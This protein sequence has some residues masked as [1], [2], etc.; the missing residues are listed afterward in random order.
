MKKSPYSLEQDL[1][2]R[3][4]GSD[5]DGIGG[6][7]R[8]SAEDFFVQ[9]IP[10]PSGGETGPYLVCR[11][12]KK[13]WEQQHAI[14]EIAR[15]LGISHRR[16][17]WAGTK[18]RRAVTTQLISIYKV[19][20]EMVESIRLKDIT[21]EVVGHRNT[22]LSLGDLEGNRFDITIREATD[23]DPATTVQTITR[24]IARGIPNYYGIQR[25]GGVR[26]VTH[27]VGERILAGDYEGAVVTYIGKSF[28]LENENTRHARMEFDSTRDSEDALRVFPVSLAYERAMLQHLHNNPKDYPG[29][30]QQLPPKLLSMFV[31]AFQSY[32]FNE[33]VSR[34]IEQGYTFAEPQPGDRLLFTN[35]KED[36]VSERNRH[37]ALQHIMRGRCKIAIFMPGKGRFSPFSDSEHYMKGLMEERG[38]RAENFVQASTF[39]KTKF[40]GALRP[41]M[42]Q[43]NVGTN[44]EGT[45]VRL[46]FTLPPGHY[47]TTVAREYMKTDPLQ[48][49]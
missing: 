23:P 25:F 39:V 37:T 13:N 31:S 26:P 46:Q 49:I 5:A 17:G 29:A 16:I 7:L 44:T 11:L 35:G 20:P 24:D 12:T 10:L 14:K 32:L 33:A 34:R 28:P 2:M 41:I 38:I 22:R 48:M 6:N 21:L 45:C 8:S 42:L 9:E 27:Q 36:V 47:A 15:R 43:A 30:L 40:E 4:Y 3:N 19:T 1:G 18:D